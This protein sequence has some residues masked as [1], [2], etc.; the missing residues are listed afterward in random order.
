MNSRKKRIVNLIKIEATRRARTE[1]ILGKSPAIFNGHQ[2][3]R[4]DYPYD[5]IINAEPLLWVALSSTIFYDIFIKSVKGGHSKKVKNLKLKKAW[6]E[7]VISKPNTIL[8]KNRKK[9]A[10]LIYQSVRGKSRLYDTFSSWRDSKYHVSV[11]ISR[12]GD[13]L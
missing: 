12:R 8:E 4:A 1:T 5:D 6:V 10:K 9:N 11:I 3:P 13:T 2:P 7:V